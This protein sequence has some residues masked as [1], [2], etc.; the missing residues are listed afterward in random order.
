MGCRW[1]VFAK[2]RLNSS[3][4]QVSFVY[5]LSALLLREGKKCRGTPVKFILKG[6]LLWKSSVAV[7]QLDTD[8]L[9]ENKF[10]IRTFAKSPGLPS[11]TSRRIKPNS[12]LGAFTG[13]SIRWLYLCAGEMSL[14]MCRW[15]IK[16]LQYRGAT[17]DFHPIR[18]VCLLSNWNKLTKNLR[19]APTYFCF[20]QTFKH[21]AYLPNAEIEI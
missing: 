17:L 10:N 1:A 16:M 8:R 2:T 12:C 9:R 19:S 3:Q 7:S 13:C 11:I 15:F 21:I 18:L 20:S 14:E 5:T 6:K 4:T